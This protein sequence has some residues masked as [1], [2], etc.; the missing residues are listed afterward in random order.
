MAKLEHAFQ[1]NVENSLMA[2]ESAWAQ[3]KMV[4]RMEHRFES[5]SG[6]VEVRDDARCHEGLPVPEGRHVT[7]LP[8]EGTMPGVGIMQGA[9]QSHGVLTVREI[10]SLLVRG[11]GPRVRCSATGGYLDQMTSRQSPRW[12]AK[13]ITPVDC[14]LAAVARVAER[15]AALH[16]QGQCFCGSFHRG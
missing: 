7:A 13:H 3:P 16:R 4:C 9:R 2:N 15:V 1:A 11:D 12:G 8:R 14:A 5:L 10:G 6:S